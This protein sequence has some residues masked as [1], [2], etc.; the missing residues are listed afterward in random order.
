PHKATASFIIPLTFDRLLG[1]LAVTAGRI[2]TA[3][4]HYEDGLAFCD[5]AGYRPEYAWTAC[6]YAQALHTRNRT[7]DRDKAAQIR[8]AARRIAS[9]LSMRPV[10]ERCERTPAG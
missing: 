6:D 1:L 8:D 3:L 5:R 9:E 2:D 4:R 10:L 7:G